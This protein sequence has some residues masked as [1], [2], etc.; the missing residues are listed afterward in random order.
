M[1]SLLE[2]WPAKFG[3]LLSI[4]ENSGFALKGNWRQ[5]WGRGELCSQWHPEAPIRLVH[6]RMH[7][8]QRMSVGR[9][10]IMALAG[11]G[12]RQMFQGGHQPSKYLGV[13]MSRKWCLK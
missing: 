4:L 7:C 10:M 5:P 1:E 11:E 8:G 13:G 3:A 9:F 6:V 12:F 2:D